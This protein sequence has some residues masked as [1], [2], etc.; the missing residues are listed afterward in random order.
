MLPKVRTATGRLTT[1]S[2]EGIANIL[3]CLDSPAF[4]IASNESFLALN[5]LAL[6]V[7][8][9]KNEIIIGKSFRLFFPNIIGRYNSLFTISSLPDRTLSTILLTKNHDR[10]P[11]TLRLL[12]LAGQESH[13]LITFEKIADQQ[14]EKSENQRR[15]HLLMN[16]EELFKAVSDMDSIDQILTIASKLLITNALT[17]YFCGNNSPIFCKVH[18]WGDTSFLPDEIPPTDLDHF[19]KSNY[20]LKDQRTVSTSLHQAVRVSDHH[21]LATAP[22]GTDGAWTGFIAATGTEEPDTEFT[23]PIL[24]VVAE[25]ISLK[26]QYSIRISNIE[27]NLEVNSKKI[28]IG[29]TVQDTIQEGII[30]ISTS[31]EI[32]K[33]NAAAEYMLGY[34]SGE[35]QGQTVENVL[36]GTDRLIPAIRLALKGVPTHNLGKTM[37]HRRDGSSFPV[38]IHTTPVTEKG[39][40]LGALVN[41]VDISEHEQAQFRT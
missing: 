12:E 17:V 4:I 28:A 31:F 25:A 16:I 15:E 6:E 20:W 21:Y 23:L 24:Q 2:V 33:L 11:V 19:L 32:T 10:I 40:I 3:E 38:Q 9:Y 29:D 27:Q 14:R 41:L 30:L 37:L 5:S 1:L 26:S 35:I 18:S 34:A 22:I 7:S 8:G 39:E 13:Y 36:I